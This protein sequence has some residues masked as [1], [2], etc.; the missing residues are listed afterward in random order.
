MRHASSMRSRSGL[1]LRGAGC[2]CRSCVAGGFT[3]QVLLKMMNSA[4]I[5]SSRMTM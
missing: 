4:V 3:R 1:N 5:R 2:Y